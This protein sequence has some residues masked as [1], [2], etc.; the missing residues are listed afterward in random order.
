MSACLCAIMVSPSS[1]S[2]PS[3]RMDREGGRHNNKQNTRSRA[4]PSCGRG[5]L[6]IPDNPEAVLTGIKL[7][8]LLKHNI[9]CTCIIKSCV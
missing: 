3:C 2:A 4:A 9:A 1:V 7:G 6:S 8:L 5:V